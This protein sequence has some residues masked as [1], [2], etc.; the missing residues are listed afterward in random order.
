LGVTQGILATLVA[1]G[2]ALEL[3][4]FVVVSM[5]IFCLL[6]TSIFALVAA[7]PAIANDDR[8]RGGPASI[9][10]E[11]KSCFAVN[12][13][14]EK[15]VNTGRY[16]FKIYELKSSGEAQLYLEVRMRC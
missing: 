4:S 12:R 1:L 13:A 6:L 16:T 3:L 9:V 5:R 7:F 11:D 8:Y 14:Y 15:M 10:F 2:F